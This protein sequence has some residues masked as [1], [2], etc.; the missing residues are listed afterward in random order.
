MNNEVLNI[1]HVIVDHNHPIHRQVRIRRGRKYL[2]KQRNYPPETTKSVQIRS[3]M[4]EVQLSGPK[5]EIW[6]SVDFRLSQKY[7]EIQQL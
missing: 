3:Y 6:G 5:P 7:A 4:P 1:I 2:R